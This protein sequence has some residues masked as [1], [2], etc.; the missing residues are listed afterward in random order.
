MQ[1][2]FPFKHWIGNWG[3]CLPSGM[4]GLGAYA[5]DSSSRKTHRFI[6]DQRIYKRRETVC[7]YT[8]LE[9][10]QRSTSGYLPRRRYVY[11]FKE[12]LKNSNHKKR[13][14]HC[15]RRSQRQLKIDRESSINRERKLCYRTTTTKIYKGKIK[16][17]QRSTKNNK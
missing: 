8:S 16:E 1:S 9:H 14:A 6:Q 3:C 5:L 4:R 2:S 11:Q 17:P 15:N 7:S 13:Q 10:K 12:S